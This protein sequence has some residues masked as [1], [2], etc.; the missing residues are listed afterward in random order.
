MHKI[1]LKNSTLSNS[2]LIQVIFLYKQISSLTFSLAPSNF[3]RKRKN[4]CSSGKKM[5]WG[6]YL[7]G[8]V[9]FSSVL[10]DLSHSLSICLVVSRINYKLQLNCFV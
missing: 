7:S 3:Q 2:L 6:P 8:T 10:L 9:P 5:T 1:T 4:G